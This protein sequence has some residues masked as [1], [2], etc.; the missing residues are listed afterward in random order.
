VLGAGAAIDGAIARADHREPGAP[1]EGGPS[2]GGAWFPAGVWARAL[3]VYGLVLALLLVVSWQVV[4]RY[5]EHAQGL[6]P[7]EVSGGWFWDGWVRYDAGWYT[8]IADDGYS[9]HPGEPSSVAFFP[10][11]PALVRAVGGVI[12]NTALAGIVVT[13]VSA[14][15]AFVVYH[16]WCRA[17]LGGEA[18][19]VA[20]LCL[21]LYPFAFYLYGAVYS[22]A[23]FLLCALVAFVAFE[24]D[25][26]ALAGVAG[27]AASATRLVGLA[28]AIALVVGVVERRRVLAGH[29]GRR[30]RHRVD[31]SR[32]RPHDTWVLLAFAGFVGWSGFLRR[33]FGDPLLFSTVQASWGQ[34]GGLDTWFKRDFFAS[35][36][37]AGDDR[38]Y[39]YGLLAH[40]A[41]SVGV[42][43]SVPGVARRFG[44]RYGAYVAVVA[45][46]PLA[47]SQDFQ[48]MGRYLLVA[49][50]SFALLGAVLAE[51]PGLR[52]LVLPLS[53]AALVAYTVGF[54]NGRYVA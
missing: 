17:R 20:L 7:V 22:E 51:R 47:G 54:A 9:H 23:L 2:V 43:W 31:V 12:G 11:Y 25:H 37:G 40:L 49:F 26:L 52:R 16:G 45:I 6:P 8:L 5:T 19:G 29:G 28:V 1:E 41:V 15:G 46:I 39:A 21:A 27:A 3:G 33:R 4:A 53:A 36:L 34:G 32:L 30:W 35:V 13:L 14:A 50:P 44:V 42:V 18:A 10:G 38:L 24:R 48:C